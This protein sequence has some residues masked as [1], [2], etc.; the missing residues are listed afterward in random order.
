[1]KSTVNAIRCNLDMR[2]M[3][4]NCSVNDTQVSKYKLGALGCYYGKHYISFVWKRSAS[5][6]GNRSQCWV[7]FDDKNAHFMK[8]WKEVQSNMIAGRQQATFLIYRK[9]VRIHGTPL[10]VFVVM[11]VHY[12]SNSLVFLYFASIKRTEWIQSLDP[13][14]PLDSVHGSCGSCTGGVCGPNRPSR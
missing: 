13:Q 11:V 10:S 14:A 3:F 7:R 2:S 9:V 1:M 4:G 6:V 12:L 8:N 5:P